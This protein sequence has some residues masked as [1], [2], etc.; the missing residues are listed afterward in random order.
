MLP[1]HYN[2]YS[3]AVVKDPLDFFTT[4]LPEMA[5]VK[6]LFNSCKLILELPPKKIILELAEGSRVYKYTFLTLGVNN[7]P[8]GWI[9]YIPEERRLDVYIP[10]NPLIPILQWK[11][12]KCEFKNYPMLYDRIGFDRLFDR[13]VNIL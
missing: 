5:K 12:K 10:E 2:M 1:T 9:I 6:A 4:N 7:I 13:F 11:G 8:F 3:Y